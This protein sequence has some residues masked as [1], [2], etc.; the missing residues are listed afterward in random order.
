MANSGMHP[1]RQAYVEEAEPE[2]SISYPKHLPSSHVSPCS[3]S[4]F[5]RRNR[6][7]ELEMREMDWQET[8]GHCVDSRTQRW[9]SPTKKYV[10]LNI[11]ISAPNSCSHL[12]AVDHDYNI[13]SGAAPE[14][15]SAILAQF[16]RKRFA[17]TIAV[18]TDD[19]KVR[20]RL[21]ELGEPIT[22]F[23]ETF[24]ERRDRLREFLTQ[25]A[26]AGDEE[27]VDMGDAGQEGEAE[28][29]YFTEGTQELLN[30]RKDIARYSLPKAKERIA[31]Q[32]VESTIPL[33]THV[34]HRK[35]I[36]ER[37]QEFELFGSQIASDRPIG[38]VRFAPSGEL[39]AAGTWSGTI[40]IL[41]VPN[42]D[43][44]LLLRG[45]SDVVSGISWMPG[46]TLPGSDISPSTVNLASGG[47][48][49]N[50][51]LWSLEQDTPLATLS[52][53][54]GRVSRVEF[55]PSRKYL[56][57]ASHDMTW[58]LWDIETS[59]ELLLQEGHSREV[60]AI[61]FNTDGSLVASAGHDSIGR[62]WDL[63][64]GR[65]VMYLD[66][67]IQ[68]IYGVDWGS[69]G[70]RV[71]TGSADGFVKC[72]DVRAVKEVANIGAH[73]GGVNDLRWYK[74]TDGPANVALPTK[75]DTG[76][77]IPKKAGTF[78]VSCGFD[79]EVKIFSADDWAP[80]KSLTA[81]AG[82]VTGV[83]VSLDS[84]WIASCGRD[85][86]VKLWQRPD[87]EGI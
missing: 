15:A 44:K 61:S 69:D 4:S 63:R 2:V 75:D 47:G 51:N 46:A 41:D 85:R 21:R 8:D 20:L 40:K 52:G 33:R 13:G 5:R 76:D 37:L 45:H 87:E 54:E 43:D 56:A 64:T 6:S 84:K 17:A 10:S 48:E 1:S 50:V 79:K 60:H 34:K 70:Y 22:L 19:K 31:Y 71:L 72:W 80:C 65:M 39:V 7:M 53:H 28:E 18:P 57:T 73:I 82:N 3:H 38:T 42:L 24:A 23:G 58:R 36:K 66:S 14:K 27:D 26:E 49:G 62:I 11:L 74:G 83:D 67:H 9:A 59:T 16:D 25:R 81:H 12:T 77:Y 35:A 86:T 68:P 78:F 32:K 30:S 29:E 55:H